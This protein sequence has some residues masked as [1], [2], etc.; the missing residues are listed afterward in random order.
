[1]KKI[2]LLSDTHTFL[3]PEIF[4]FFEN[5]DEIWHAG[6]IGN[7]ETADS[8]ATFKPLVAVHGNIDDAKIRLSYPEIQAF[9]CENI[10]VLMIHIGGYPG[11]YARGIK[12]LIRIERPNLFISGHSHIL[13]VINDPKY[14]LLHMNP[15]AAGNSGLHKQQTFMRFKI[16]GKRISDLEVFDIN[17]H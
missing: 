9:S 16:D 14:Q 13:K 7:S 3:H 15:G 6:D 17:R 2:G 4:E 12:N 1:M 5:V 11:N 8:L 10:K